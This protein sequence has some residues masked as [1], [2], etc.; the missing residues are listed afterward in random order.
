M[1]ALVGCLVIG[2]AVY[3][4]YR[5][6]EVR[7]VLLL[8]GLGLGALAGKMNLIVEKF[9]L[10]LV[11]EK[12]VVPICTALGF[13]Y[14]IRHTGCDEHL[15][16]LLVNPLKKVRALL[17]PGTVLVGFLVN[18]PIVSQTSTAVTIGPVVIPLLVAARIS[19]PTIGAAILL[20]S[21]IGG[22]LFNP[23][24]PE[25]RTVVTESK[26]AVAG[27]ANENGDQKQPNLMQENFGTDRC[28]RRIL[29][30]NL[31]GFAAATGLF[32]IMTWRREQYDAAGAPATTTPD[33]FRVNIVKAMIPLIPLV[34]LY[35]T[36][37]LFRIVHVE[38]HW[39]VSDAR[40]DDGLFDS[41][42]IGSAM[43]IGSA[44]A[45]LV[46]WRKGLGIAAAFFEGAGYGYA[47]VIS[48][49]VTA[50]CF[51]EGIKLLELAKGP[52]GWVAGDPAL[53]L[54][55]A[56]SVALGFAWLSGSGMAATQS[57][58]LFFAKPSLDL[59]I[60]P[61]HTGAVVSLAAAAGRTMSPVSAVNLMTAK[62]TAT[63][64]LQLSRLVAVPLLVSTAIII[65]VAILIRMPP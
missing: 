30:L 29:P 1:M 9:F 50:S 4:V 18:M 8:A 17:I 58:F 39:L 40:A 5:Q 57:L 35:L 16:R 12:F 26:K 63:T 60:D 48:L 52:G 47:N 24:A 37:P 28:V 36:S 10:T 49:I 3:A 20:G 7:L 2:L 22:E 33:E 43:L 27:L 54:A 56:G 38:R 64:P 45:G 44:V 6:V 21:S 42:L 41:R 59:G 25:L 14:V 55:A 31:I 46:V 62:L 61:T 19:S 51:G 15:V 53:F 23:G 65:V 34:I 13:A 32:W 11:D